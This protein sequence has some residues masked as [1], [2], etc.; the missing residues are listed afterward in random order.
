MYDSTEWQAD[1][2]QMIAEG[3][4]DRPD[5]CDPIILSDEEADAAE[6]Q[7]AI[8]FGFD[9]FSGMTPSEFLASRET[10]VTV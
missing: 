9:P 10:L 8:D 5:T 1:Y 6:L 7:M 2:E 3:I 4:L